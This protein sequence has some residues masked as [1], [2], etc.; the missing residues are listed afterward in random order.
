[1]TG[2]GAKQTF[3]EN[4]DVSYARLRREPSKPRTSTGIE[5][6]R[7]SPPYPTIFF[8]TIAP[9]FR[10]R[11]EPDGLRYGFELGCKNRLVRPGALRISV[12]L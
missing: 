6:Q 3:G 7:I 10:L 5:R 12:G 4:Y 8:I 2:I 1:V 9:D 11:C